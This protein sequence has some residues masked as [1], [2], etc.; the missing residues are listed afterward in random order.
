VYL[1]WGRYVLR[2]PMP[3]SASLRSAPGIHMHMQIEIAATEVAKALA[4][5]R[6]LVMEGS[7]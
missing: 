3:P 1:A 2:A 6:R 4:G 5:A 7:R